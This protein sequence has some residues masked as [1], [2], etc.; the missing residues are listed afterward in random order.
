MAPALFNSISAEIKTKN[1]A[2]SEAEGY[3]FR[4]NG[5]TLKFDGFLKVYQI[6]FEERDLPDLEKNDQLNL[7]KLNH[8]QHFTEPPARY[9]EASLIKALEKHGIGRPSTYAP[10]LTTIQTRSYIE[11]NEQKRFFPTE[12]GIMVND[13][14]VENFPEIV[15]IDFTAK[16]EKELDQIAKGKDTL[17]KTCRDFYIPFSKNLKEKYENVAK[18]KF[19]ETP[20]DRKCPK[21]S[22]HLIEKMG[23]FGRFYSCSKFPECKHTEPI[24]DNGIKI[25]CPKC[26]IGEIVS[27]RTKKGKIFYG[28]D[29]FPKCDFATWD[30]PI[31]EM[32]SECGSILVETKRKQIKCSNK[33][34]KNWI[35]KY[36]ES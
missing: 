26:K 7:I 13:V 35:M 14:L 30:K 28:C 6:K 2:L 22:S 8:S 36:K 23:R 29:Q 16:L 24:K 18:K 20:T 10:T 21:C 3:T 34:C 1:P 27:K 15:N 9:N 33:E 31:N 25:K 5:Q 32:C 17:V 19:T 4:A 11:K 12:M